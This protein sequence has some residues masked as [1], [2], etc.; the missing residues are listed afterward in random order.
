MADES[1]T[2]WNPRPG[3]VVRVH[4]RVKETTSKGEEKER[5]QVFEGTVIARRHGSEPGATFTVRKLSSGIGVERIFPLRAPTIAKVE[6][7][8]RYKVRRAKLSYLRGDYG[9]KLREVAGAKS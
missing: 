7:V 2:N 4:L 8:K 3:E 9:K 1:K 6:T 5:V